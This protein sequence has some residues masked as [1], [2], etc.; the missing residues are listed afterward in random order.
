[1][2]ARLPPLRYVLTLSGGID[3]AWQVL[4]FSITEALDHP[5][6]ATVE[7]VAAIEYPEVESCLGR[8]A[9]LLIARGAQAQALCGVVSRVDYLAFER[10][11]LHLRFH[12]ASALGILDQR[13]NSRI[14]QNHSVREIVGQVLGEGLGEYG[15]ELD[16]GETQR[17]D[18]RRDYCVQYRE[19][20]F[21][22]VSRLLEE[23][24]I[25]YAFE[26]DA[27]SQR[28]TVVLRDDNAQYGE[29]DNFGHGS[30]L[31][32]ILSNPGEADVE[33]IQGFEWSAAMTSTGVLR[34]DFDWLTQPQLVS[35]SV[36]EADDHGRE[37][38]RFDHGQRRFIV[39]DLRERIDDRHAAEGLGARVLR[40]HGNATAMRPGLRFVLRDDAH[41]DFEVEYL[42][43]RV[44]HRGGES[45]EEP[46]EGPTATYANRFECVPYELPHRPV[47]KTPKPREFGPQ[48]AIVTGPASEEI[49]TD[50]HGR[51]K[52][53][54]YWE[55]QADYDAEASCWIRCA[56]QWA[57]VGWGAQFIPRVGME[58]VVEFLEGNPDR[59]LVTG[60]VYNSERPTPFLLPQRKTQSG[61]RT[62]SSPGGAGF[63]ELRFEDAAGAEEIYL[64]GERDWSIEIENDKRQQVGRDEQLTV[65][66]ERTKAVG[67]NERFVVGVNLEGSVGVHHSLTVGRDQSVSVG[68]ENNLRV[69]GNVIWDIAKDLR[70]RVGED[71]EQSVSAEMHTSVGSHYTL[72]V[73]GDATTTITGDHGVQASSATLAT[74]ADL[75]LSSDGKLRLEAGDRMTVKGEEKL[76][77]EAA[78][79]LT[80]RCG[81]ASLTLSEDGKVTIKG[82]DIKIKGSGNVSVKGQSVADN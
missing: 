44:E 82:S 39:D 28:E 70:L 37:R 51:V 65:V 75:S 23:E 40:G 80:L 76:I 7:A 58:V 71:I 79:K 19:S 34:R 66:R 59:P 3:A 21:A 78:K 62:D 17:G 13:V 26:H 46:R 42:I 57:G 32:V 49:H 74:S 14:W 67:V 47:A 12:I 18:E 24:G 27:E 20:D 61:W 5:Y 30:E 77:V 69:G 15:R 8:S 4:S 33:S 72:D 29:L 2:Y 22:F 10:G 43:T 11:E 53:Q 6:T 25:C 81:D 55:E 52:V 41:H 56:Q 48:T 64:H 54:F 35:A 50:E 16:L 45:R 68:G 63:N 60:C 38:R 73:G 9:A 1:M 36:G 31:P